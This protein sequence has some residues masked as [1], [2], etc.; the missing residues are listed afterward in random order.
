MVIDSSKT[1]VE[2]DRKA[3]S[4]GIYI[5]DGQREPLRLLTDLRI[6]VSLWGQGNRFVG[7]INSM[8]CC[9]QGGMFCPIFC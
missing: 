7:I 4:L 8:D 2:Y 1:R 5:V 3:A 9:A 6:H